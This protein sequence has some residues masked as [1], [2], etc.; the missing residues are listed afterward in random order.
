[1]ES[2]MSS[3]RAAAVITGSLF[4]IAMFSSLLGGGLLETVLNSPDYLANIQTNASPLW[5]GV[6]LELLNGIAVAGIAI[7]MFPVL[8]TQNESVAM[9][10]VGFRI[11]ESVFCVLAALMPVLLIS[12]SQ[13][14]LNAGE[15]QGGN[16][17]ELANVL[18]SVRTQLAGLLIPLFFG[19]G[20]LLLYSSMYISGLVPRFISVWGI[21][22][23]ILVLVLN[24]FQFTPVLAIVLALPI[25]LNEI[26]LGGWL[27]VK[28]FNTTS[29][30]H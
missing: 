12:L 8:K 22:A 2:S 14:Y 11:I 18:L 9:A 24:I 17:Q 3:N 23:V 4:L 19:L 21:V 26:F 28:G 6:S 16:Y 5:T 27:I 7:L 10:Y 1:M 25:I 20:A 13:A 29:S 30:Q 15:S